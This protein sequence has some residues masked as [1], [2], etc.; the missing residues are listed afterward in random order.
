[1]F[2]GTWCEKN[3]RITM[4]TDLISNIGKKNSC[5]PLQ[6]TYSNNTSSLD[7]HNPNF[8]TQGV[9]LTKHKFHEIDRLGASIGKCD[10][11][12]ISSHV[13]TKYNWTCFNTGNKT[14]RDFNWVFVECV[15][16]LLLSV[17][18][19]TSQRFV[20]IID[21]LCGR[22]Q[23]VMSCQEFE[24]PTG[25]VWCSK[26]FKIEKTYHQIIAKQGKPF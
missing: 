15:K 20:Q 19:L 9:L 6:T 24:L 17:Q 14:S 8:P 23:E 22:E 1:M 13:L 4:Y 2:Q 12:D 25:L 3:E 16:Q 26:T 11:T 21:R 7:N 10:V 5:E 18:C